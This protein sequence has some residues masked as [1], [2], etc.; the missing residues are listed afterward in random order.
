MLYDFISV[1]GATRDI[2]FFTDQGI[3]LDNHR[4]ILRQKLLAFEY[5]AKI[6]V[7]KFYYTFGGGAANTAVNIA[8]FGFKT[9]CLAAVGDDRHGR[10][11][12]DN[13]KER[14]VSARL[15]QKFKRTESGFSFVLIAPSGERI[16]F[17]E[18]GAN[19]RLQIGLKQ[20][21]LLRQTRNIYLSSLSG[22]WDK[23]ARAI[24]ALADFPGRRIYWNPGSA[25]YAAGLEKIGRFLKKT[26]V[27]FVNKDEAIELALS[28]AGRACPSNHFLNNTRNLLVAIKALGPQIVVITSGAGG[29][30]AYDG[31]HF[32]HQAILKEKKRVD[33]T[34][35]GDIFNS[36][37]AA[38]LEIY[39]GNIKAALHLGI[40]NT[41]AKIAHLGAQN[42]LLNFRLPK[43]RRSLRN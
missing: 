21:V 18:R 1:G 3:L 42:G 35:V 40:K 27:L 38:G 29:V 39:Q 11:I 32:Y 26:F 20:T 5:G 17:S 37:F 6:R 12:I 25:Q 33:T 41:A 23:T 36:S 14:G 7:D 15:I 10:L 30:D 31:R 13:L 22:A 2:A 8:H 24:F 19:D 34:G 9:A 43:K 28:A 4:D 16:I